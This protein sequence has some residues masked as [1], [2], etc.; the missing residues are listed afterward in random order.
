MEKKKNILNIIV[1]TS[2]LWSIIR[3]SGL[4]KSL[5]LTSPRLFLIFIIII[6]LAGWFTVF[7][8]PDKSIK[9]IKKASF[10]FHL[11]I[12]LF[13]ISASLFFLEKKLLI[14]DGVLY[15]IGAFI[16]QSHPFLFHIMIFSL[17]LASFLVINLSLSE[18]RPLRVLLSKNL[19]IPESVIIFIAC[20]LVYGAFIPLRDNYYPSHDY[21]IFSY[22]GQQILRGKMPY[23][24][25]WDHKPPVIF[26][27]NALGLK[28]ANGSLAGI[29]L[30]EF[31]MFFAGAIILY[32]IL[33]KNYPRWVSM[34][35]L[36][37]GILHYVRLLDFGNYTEEIS[38]FFSICALGLF[39][40]NF[41]LRYR[42]LSGFVIGILCGL[43]FTSKQNTIGCWTSLFFIDLLRLYSDRDTKKFLKYWLSAGFGFLL[44]NLCWVIY[45]AANNAL[46]AYWDIA[47]RFNFIYSEKSSDSRIACAA[48][49]LTFLPSVSLYL[50]TGFLSYIPVCLN[51]TR[52]KADL[53]AKRNELGSWALISLPIELLFAGLS[54]MNYQ[55]YFILC[56]NPVIVLL[57][58]LITA[59][60]QRL[61]YKKWLIQSC[62]VTLLFLFSLPLSRFFRENY[63][64]RTP[65][66]YT[67]TR[68]FLLENTVPDQ[69]ILVWGSRSAIYVM[70]ERYAPTAYF[71]E[72]PLYLFPDNIKTAQWEELLSDLQKDPPQ[73]VVYTHDTALPFIRQASSECIFPSEDNY[74]IPVYTF[75]CENYQYKT[76]INPEFR[77]A[78]DIYSRK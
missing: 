54:G 14:K 61:S 67:K 11:C 49:T 22:F 4:P 46:S 13:L 58:E 53:P 66:S 37:F 56:I 59:L 39:F 35:V 24:E 10:C 50:L 16:A 62:V 20:I 7:S 45:F 41:N 52:K 34:P 6:T 28:L 73:V 51:L 33:R 70:S 8:H 57:C 65:S 17:S 1:I 72:R 18:A 40:S 21:A 78:W 55:H 23:T 9:N 76:T 5:H 26:Y 77:D 71:N 43:A 29:W 68:D 48:T 74:S 27:L 25:L 31:L 38:L 60:T 32:N 30:V 36:F 47:F 44:I 63:T 42:N 3:L 15:M 12:L 19:I 69:S 2:A 75:F 64:H